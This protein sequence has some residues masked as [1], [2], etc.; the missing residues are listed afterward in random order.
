M[1]KLAI[2][3]ASAFQ[4]PLI[5][6][7]KERGIET[8]VFAW[9]S[10][11]VGEETADFF[12]P[13]SITEFDKITETCKKIGVDGVCTIGTDLGNITVSYVA[14]QLGLTANSMDCVR[15][16][17]NKHL[18]REAFEVAN[19]P[20][21]R[22]IQVDL[23]TNLSELNFDFPIIV[24]PEDRSGSRGVTRLDSPDGL[25]DA[26]HLAIESG[27]DGKALVEEF[28]SGLECSVEFISWQ[29][30]HHLVSITEKFTTGAPG[31]IETGHLEPARVSSEMANQIEQVVS[32]AL[33]ALG[34]RFGASH[35]EIKIDH[36]GR[37]KLIEI[38]SRMGGDCIGS[39]LVFISTG[40]DY[41]SA[42]IDVALGIKPS[43][44][45]GIRK[46]SAAIR[47]VFSLDDVEA[48]EDIKENSPEILVFASPIDSFDRKI[49]D[50]GSRYGFYIFASEE[51]KKIE[52]YLPTHDLEGW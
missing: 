21:P 12:Y 41:V 33:D 5:L 46:K 17:T 27:F 42:V 9:E 1:T 2:I 10:G 29:G 25:C 44:P 4:N 24:K 38:G 48:L 35:S 3:G 30:E 39:D 15:K 31:F 34:V 13:L 40:Y 28:V 32:H 50:S 43:L 37:V 11:E 23:D 14:D 51:F 16:S 19:C 36:Q 47:F 26:V 45:Q 7:A 52:A 20:S 8:H 22:S 6:K 49:V 18:M